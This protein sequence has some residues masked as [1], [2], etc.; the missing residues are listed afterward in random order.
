MPPHRI[1]DQL[2][3]GDRHRDV[4]L[5]GD[6]FRGREAPQTFKQLPL[7]RFTPVTGEVDDREADVI[8]VR[9]RRQRGR[10]EACNQLVVCEHS[11]R[12]CSF[13]AAAMTS[14]SSRLTRSCMRSSFHCRTAFSIWSATERRLM[15]QHFARHSADC[16]CKGFNSNSLRSWSTTD[17]PKTRASTETLKVVTGVGILAS[18]LRLC[19]GVLLRAAFT[20]STA[21]GGAAASCGA[22]P[23][24]TGQSAAANE[25]VITVFR[26]KS[27]T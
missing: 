8:G 27:V 1:F 3:P 7:C 11:Y 6:A 18:N 2:Q 24:E 5:L 10:L 16:L 23:A 15:P 19:E 4:K 25:R 14:A 9:E 21:S 12:Y 13:S 22:A 26:S 20:C 17:S